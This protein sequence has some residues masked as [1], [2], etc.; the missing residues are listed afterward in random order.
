[1]RNTENTWE[2]YFRRL[3]YRMGRYQIMF[4]FLIVALWLFAVLH[5]VYNQND[6]SGQCDQIYEV[7]RRPVYGLVVK[8]TRRN[9]KAGVDNIVV[10]DFSTN[11]LTYFYSERLDSASNI[12]D[13]LLKEANSTSAYLFTDGKRLLMIVTPW[14][15]A[16][17][18]WWREHNPDR[19]KL[20]DSLESIERASG[21]RD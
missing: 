2:A 13:T 19:A 15:P 11:E 10:R 9:S 1:M 20:I 14:N 3:S 4:V 12:G 16:C 7:I 17:P 6:H 5:N 18:E 21:L 8:K